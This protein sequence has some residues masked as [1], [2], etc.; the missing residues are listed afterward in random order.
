M[1]SRA[2]LTRDFLALGVVPGD[3]VMMHASVRAVGDSAGGPDDIHLALRDALTPEGTLIMYAGCPR[4]ID[5]VG[6]GGLNAEDEAEVLEKVL[7]FDAETARADRSNGTLVE[8]FRSY[9]GTRVNPHV[10]RFAAWGRQVDHLFESQPWD[11]AYG[12]GSALERFVAL[13]GRILTVGSDHD[14]VTF[15]HYVEHIVDIPDK[16]IARFKVPVA[17]QGARVWRDMAEV[18]SSTGAHAHWPD[19][20]FARIVDTH[21]TATGNRGSRVGDATCHLIPARG[22]LEF[23]LTVM[24]DVAAD[25]RAADTLQE[26]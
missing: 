23:A 14:T 4:Y 24:R 18:D 7:P 22:L 25:P 13:D 15:L 5:E 21:L 17:E 10:A 9:P 8:F 2:Q 20:F 11:F 12:H 19:R 1:H 16:R 3:V 6:R 26:A